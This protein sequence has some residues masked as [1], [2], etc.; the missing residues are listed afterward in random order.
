MKY[1][2]HKSA[3]RKYKAEYLSQL[4]GFIKKRQAECSEKRK[5]YIKDLFSDQE[6][7]RNDFKN[8]LGWPLNDDEEMAKIPEVKLV[9]LSRED[10]YTLYRM[11]IEILDGVWLTGLFFRMDGDDA[12][13]LVFVQ[14][15][16]WGTPEFMSG[17]YGSTAN[18][19]DMLQ[20]IIKYNV[21]AFAP[22]LLLWN[23]STYALGVDRVSID[24]RLKRVGS[25]ITAVEVGGYRKAM[26]YFE[27]QS[28]VK[29]FGMVGLSYGGFYTLF[30]TASDTRIKSAISCS[31]FNTRDAYPWTD[32][33]WWR[34]AEHFDDAE[35]AALVYPRK[36]CIEFGHLDEMFEFEN[37]K[38]SFERLTELCQNSGVGTDWVTLY[39]F[40]GI[41]E[42]CRDNGP[43]EKMLN[44]L[45]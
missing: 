6:S 41:H 4:E 11:Q 35:V 34:A 30:T 15:G 43:I 38:R 10:G 21:H 37:T 12:K 44:D 16:G 24:A 14:H 31:F 27:N 19:N 32:W 13:P 18:D 23:P 42:F 3:S 26:N 9:E 1:R 39:D 20:R 29:S 33:T 5:D 7:Y 17:V 25:S 40:D 8:M 36:L 2:E 22:Q 45:K 28:Y